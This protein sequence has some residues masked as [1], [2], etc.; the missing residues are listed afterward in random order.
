[1]NHGQA[2]ATADEDP[3]TYLPR[4]PVQ[5]FA[6]R[7]L[8]YGPQQ[9]SGHLYLA[10][11]GRVRV[12][13]QA[14]DDRQAIAAIVAP[15]QLF[16]EAALVGGPCA[17]TA[18]ALDDVTL[19]SWSRVEIELYIDREP[20]LGLALFHHMVRR[21]LELQ[22]RIEGMAVHRTPERVMLSLARL[23]RSLGTPLGDGALRI[24]ALTHHTLAEYVGTSREIVTYQLNRLRRA[25]LLRYSRQ[26]MDVYADALLEAVRSSVNG[27]P[28]ALR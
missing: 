15:E 3:L 6:R 10:V 26:H 17:E 19:M 21:C 4:K 25:G 5:E 24:D 12:A 13:R 16:G 9:P 14:E 23:A 2:I 27:R 28:P 18:S 20:R 11:R 1:M 22:E 7:R 8:I